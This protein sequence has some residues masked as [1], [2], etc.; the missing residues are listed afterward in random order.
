MNRNIYLIKINKYEFKWMIYFL[1]DNRQI[2]KKNKYKNKQ[3]N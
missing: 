3:N 1:N 2:Q